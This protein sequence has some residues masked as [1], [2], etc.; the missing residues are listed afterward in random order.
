MIECGVYNSIDCGYAASWNFWTYCCPVND[1][2]GHPSVPCV[3]LPCEI[4]EKVNLT[5]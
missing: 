3:T 4:F 1:G 5:P 2:Q